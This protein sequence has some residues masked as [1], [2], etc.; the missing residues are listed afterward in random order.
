MNVCLKLLIDAEDRCVL[1]IWLYGNMPLAVLASAKFCCSAIIAAVI[2]SFEIAEEPAMQCLTH[3]S[4]L[5]PHQLLADTMKACLL[6]A[7]DAEH[8][9]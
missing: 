7:T 8:M 2:C 1:S 5:L 6:N 4:A 3:G 9:A